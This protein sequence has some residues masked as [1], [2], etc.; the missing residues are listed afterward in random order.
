[1]NIKKM[2]LTAAAIVPLT[3]L[4]ACGE[5]PELRLGT[6]NPGGIYYQY[7]T[8]LRELDESGLAV[9]KTEGSQANMRLMKER[10][11]DLAIVQSDVLAEAVSGT[12]DF[13]NEPVSGV[14]AVAGLYYEAFQII[15]RSDSGIDEIT[16]LKDKKMS[17]G[18]AGSGVAKN[19]DYLLTSAGISA[20]SV[21]KMN[22]SYA[23]SAAALE[24]GDIDA[25]FVVLGAPSTVVT[26]LAESTDINVLPL[27]E[28]TISAMTDIYDGYFSMTI[29]A[30]TYRGLETDIP[31]VGVK[32]VLTADSR[33]NAEQIQKITSM[34]FSESGSIKYTVQV[35]EPD[36]DF[37]V[38]G[39][40]CSFH[41]GA[42]R[43]Y[44]SV[45][46]TVSTDPSATGSGIS[47]TAHND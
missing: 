33:V 38:V 43:Y 19:A 12:G 40:P 41:E 16:D 36:L 45:G 35:Q 23:E 3:L 46:L 10:F 42:A 18:E 39:I 28:R 11:L 22:M 20:N 26:E 29:P 15:V 25:F 21:E 9:K 44:E 4:S 31:T 37:A 17:V 27:D 14:R 34:L 24:K 30:G 1:M 8:S 13:E 6:G 2:L 47:F 5:L 7:G 32:A